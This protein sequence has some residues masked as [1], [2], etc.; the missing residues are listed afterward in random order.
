MCMYNV[1]QNVVQMSDV[2]SIVATD[3]EF[4]SCMRN[5]KNL[6]FNNLTFSLVFLLH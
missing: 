1:Y 4:T 5:V 3:N 6:L 2:I